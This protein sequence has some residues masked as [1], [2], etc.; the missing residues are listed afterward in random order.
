VEWFKRIARELGRPT[1][2]RTQP[3]ARLKTL[4]DI[5][6]LK[7][8]PLAEA[9]DHVDVKVLVARPLAS[10]ENINK[11][12]EVKRVRRRDRPNQ[13]VTVTNHAIGRVS[14]DKIDIGWQPIALAMLSL[15]GSTTKAA[16]CSE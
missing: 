15:R 14:N 12:G 6:L 7:P 4:A 2:F 13:S 9:L 10:C 5:R 3:H 16:R 8:C 11:H 1:A